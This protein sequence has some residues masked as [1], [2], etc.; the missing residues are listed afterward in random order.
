MPR[1]RHR[2]KAKP[3]QPPKPKTERGIPYSVGEARAWVEAY[4]HRIDIY[5]RELILW[6]CDRIEELEGRQIRCD[7]CKREIRP[8][9]TYYTDPP[10]SDAEVLCDDC[11]RRVV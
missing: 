11:H 3:N 8:G 9:E 5:P 4:G 10:V 1:A 7:Y 2:A 6:L